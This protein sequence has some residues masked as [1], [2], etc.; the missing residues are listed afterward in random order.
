MTLTRREWF[1]LGALALI[2]AVT[3]LWWA[4]ALWPLPSAAPDWIYRA[5]DVCFGVARNSLPSASGWMVLIAE[6]LT[7]LA[8]LFVLRGG[9]L[10]RGVRLLSQS[11]GG[12]AM[13]AG[14]IGAVAVG[15]GATALRVRTATAAPVQ[16]MRIS[17]DL[18]PVLADPAPPIG[19]VDQHGAA[20]T[21]DRFRGRPLLVGFAYAHC[22]TVC[23]RVVSDVLRARQAMGADAP[24]GLIV[25]LDPLRDTPS[26]LPAMAAQWHVDAETLVASGTVEDVDGMLDAWGV[27]RQRDPLTGEVTHP[28]LVIVVDADGIIRHR[29]TG[30]SELLAELVRR[31]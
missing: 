9:G 22:E 28:A 20:V 21:L 26:R 4:L 10:M 18:L 1:P 2:L 30:G 8:L 17:A 5:R 27:A 19:L 16:P 23:P 15:L 24:A 29:T 12:K 6:P 11:L 7:M 31:L 25:T 14:T 3:A 13:L